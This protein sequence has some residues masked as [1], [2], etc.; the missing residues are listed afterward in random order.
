MTQKIE[1]RCV[2]CDTAFVIEFDHEDDE[3]IYCPSCG[4]QL[5]E[6]EEDTIDMFGDEDWE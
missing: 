3:L 4:E 6:F 1:D 2:Y 5:P